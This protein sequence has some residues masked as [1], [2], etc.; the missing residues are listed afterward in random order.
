MK[1]VLPEDVVAL[2]PSPPSPR[3]SAQTLSAAD[4]LDGPRRLPQERLEEQVQDRY[5]T[6]QSQTG[7]QECNICH[8]R[9]EIFLKTS[10]K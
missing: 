10:L 2:R 3:R 8:P 4:A 9:R 7:F 1:S 5:L 6:Y